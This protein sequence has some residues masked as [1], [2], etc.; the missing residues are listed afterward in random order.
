M[1]ERFIPPHG[2][3]QELFSYRKAE[4]AYDATVYFGARFLDKR[5]R[6]HDQMVQ[7][8][9]SGKQKAA[10]LPA[11]SVMQQ[12]RPPAMQCIHRRPPYAHGN[13]SNGRCSVCHRRGGHRRGHT[14]LGMIQ[15]REPLT[16]SASIASVRGWRIHPPGA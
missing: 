9:R 15:G 16:V 1:S 12:Q 14:K 11:G 4:I 13:A 3:Y 6:T 8:A 2:G 10:A 7:V 5:D